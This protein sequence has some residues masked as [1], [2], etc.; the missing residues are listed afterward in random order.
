MQRKIKNRH[1]AKFVDMVISL[2]HL[3]VPVY[4]ANA[5]Y[6]II[7]AAFPMVMLLLN[8]LSYTTL[9]SGTLIDIL[10]NIIPSALMPSVTRLLNGMFASSSTTLVSVSAL[11]ALWAASRG[12]FGILVGLNRIYGVQEDRGY[13]FTR[14]L[15]LVYTFLFLLVLLLTLALHV[16]GQ[17]I[18]AR[19][20][21]S[22]NLAF[23]L[24]LDVISSRFLLLLCLQT[25]LFTAMFMFLPNRHNKLLPSLP[26]ALFASLGWLLFSD[27]FS[28][29]VEHFS[30]YS[31]VYG[32]LSAIALAMLWLYICVAIVFYGGALNKYLSDIGYQLRLR[33]QRKNENPGQD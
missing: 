7:L 6:F 13:V 22:D 31:T 23:R 30:N 1:L 26:G 20:P 3:D 29:Y 10:E 15:S 11:A 4:A 2:Y 14:L 24:L 21:E 5:A 33:R 8:L 32:S 18:L 12:V 28:I 17:T 19:I 27:F 16:F 9:G 25:A